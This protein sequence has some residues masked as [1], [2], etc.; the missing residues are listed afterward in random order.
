MNCREKLVTP[1][2]NSQ[3]QKRKKEK[4]VKYTTSITTFSCSVPHAI[5]LHGMCVCYNLQS[6]LFWSKEALAFGE[7]GQEEQMELL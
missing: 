1:L 2:L 6:Q 3:G 7:L 4:G 5:P